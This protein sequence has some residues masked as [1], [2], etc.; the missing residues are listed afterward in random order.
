MPTPHSNTVHM[1]GDDAGA[2]ARS[3]TTE[4]ARQNALVTVPDH[5]EAAKSAAALHLALTGMAAE[6][7]KPH[8]LPAHRM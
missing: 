6:P 3:I 2:P 5:A 7:R 8:K 1:Y 4:V